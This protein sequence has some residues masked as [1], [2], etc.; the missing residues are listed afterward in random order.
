MDNKSSSSTPQTSHNAAAD[1]A[2]QA[3]PHAAECPYVATAPMEVS[4]DTVAPPDIATTAVMVDVTVA[5]SQGRAPAD[6]CAPVRL[7]NY[8]LEPAE[9]AT[10][11][12][13][14][15]PHHHHFEAGSTRYKPQERQNPTPQQDAAEVVWARIYPD[16]NVPPKL[17]GTQLYGRFKKE[18]DRDPELGEMKRPSKSTLLRK[19]GKKDINKRN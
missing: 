7:V 8:V 1:S 6:L 12:A 9:L 18:W 15:E 4:T 11:P 10:G 13:V 19:L 2:A 3:S 17:T 5:G 16:G 14:F